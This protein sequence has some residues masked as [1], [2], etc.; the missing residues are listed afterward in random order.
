MENRTIPT[1]QLS[2]T[3]D[4]HW[5][6]NKY[7]IDYVCEFMQFVPVKEQ[8]KVY[9][10]SFY[11]QS[12]EKDIF[13]NDELQ[14]LNAGFRIF[15]KQLS[16]KEDFKKE[17]FIFTC[18]LYF[19]DSSEKLRRD[20]QAVIE[21]ARAK[22]KNIPGIYL[23]RIS[24]GVYIG[25]SV[26]VIS[27]LQQ[28]LKNLYSGIHPNQNLQSDWDG[29]ENF[30][31]H[32]EL[33]DYAPSTLEGIALQK[34]LEQSEKNSIIFFRSKNKRVLNIS[35][36]EFVPTASSKSEYAKAKNEYLKNYDALKKDIK[37]DRKKQKI[38][39]EKTLAELKVRRSKLFE[40]KDDA[41]KTQ[42]DIW[43]KKSAFSKLNSILI[44]KDK[45]ENEIAL[46]IK[47]VEKKIIEVSSAIRS[48]NFQLAQLRK[49]KYTE[50]EQEILK[51]LVFDRI[52]EL[53]K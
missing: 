19:D 25:Q 50:K 43:T 29:Q 4:F 28:H 9:L 14:K 36:G 27:R 11:L 40:L 20:S 12:L 16:Y 21:E 1:R 48:V 42:K 24:D 2:L 8:V 46:R 33:L 45:E 44:G 35:E 26:R 52:K 13:Y 30:D 51:S 10:E 53:E 17:K 38:N 32:F 37:T 7:N 15:L 34:W 3:L 22:F 39:L 5:K 49:R 47:V 6:F 23:I 31:F 18:E 41:I